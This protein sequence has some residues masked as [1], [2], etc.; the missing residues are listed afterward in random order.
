MGRQAERIGRSHANAYIQLLRELLGFAV[1][2]KI[3][4]DNPAEHLK[5]FK[6]EK[7]IRPTPTWEEF[8]AIVEEIRKQ[9]FNAAAEDSANFVEFIGLSGLGRAEAAALTWSDVNFERDQMIT[10]RHKTAT[11]FAVPIYPQLRPLLE[12]LKAD[13]KSGAAEKVLEI[14]DAKKAIA[15]AC[16]RLGLRHYSHIGF[17]RMFITRA[18]ERGI[19]A[20]VIA[21][22]QG[23]KD[24]GKLILDTYSHVNPVHAQRMAQLMTNSEPTNIVL[25]NKGAA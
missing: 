15:G 16:K 9:P 12:R 3:I 1:R 8:Q 4:G 23:H 7:P 10:F 17:R 2:D 5:Y 21:Q 11:G 18:I 24:G 14:S 6:R 20:K 13:A 19:D 25:L 22:W